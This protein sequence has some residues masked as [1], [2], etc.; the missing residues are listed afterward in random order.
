MLPICAPQVAAI[1]TDHIS[2]SKQHAVLVH[3]EI[4]IKDELGIGFGKMVVK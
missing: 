2:C 4:N 1:P 3:R